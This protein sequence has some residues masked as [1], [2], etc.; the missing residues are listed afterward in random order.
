MVS[1]LL[2]DMFIHRQWNFKENGVLTA[3]EEAESALLRITA[4]MPIRFSRILLGWE[5]GPCVS[6]FVSGSVT[7]AD[8]VRKTALYD[9][10]TRQYPEVSNWPAVCVTYAGR[11]LESALGTTDATEFDL[12]IMNHAG[13]R[14]LNQPGIR[15]LGG[16][17]ELT[18]TSGPAMAQMLM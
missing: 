6:G 16:P 14:F 8:A 2:E 9:E 3:R 15:W 18:V 12:S 5:T 7:D 17:Y 1:D 10:A 4:Q 13:D 11:N